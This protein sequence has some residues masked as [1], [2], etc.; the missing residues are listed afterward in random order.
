MLV[1]GATGFIGA[2]VVDE[3][4]SRGIKVRGA[5][6]SMPKGEAMLKARPNFAS[7][8]DFVQIEDFEKVGVFKDAV[9]DIDA[10]IHVASVL[11][12]FSHDLQIYD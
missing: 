6:R 9:K 3:L 4:L 8:L 7:Q 1:T 2:H 12:A 10:V 5:T 11:P